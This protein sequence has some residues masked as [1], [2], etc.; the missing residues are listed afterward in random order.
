VNGVDAALAI[1]V[2]A[3]NLAIVLMS[4]AIP[5]HCDDGIARLRLAGMLSKPFSL[6]VLREMIYYAVEIGVAHKTD[7]LSA[8][9]VPPSVQAG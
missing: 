5:A 3:P 4:G 7:E 6:A 9:I 2:I 1:Q 8:N